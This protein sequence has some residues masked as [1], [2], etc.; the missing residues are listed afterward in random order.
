MEGENS[1]ARPVKTEIPDGK[2]K[3]NMEM[4]KKHGLSDDPLFAGIVAIAMA[5][6]EQSMMDVYLAECKKVTSRHLL[7][8]PALPGFVFG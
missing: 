6:I 8:S 2:I 5:N 4:L 3:R 1:G 7:K